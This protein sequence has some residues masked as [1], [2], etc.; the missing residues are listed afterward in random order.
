MIDIKNF[1]LERYSFT[2]KNIDTTPN[3]NLGMVLV[4]PCFNEPNVLSSLLSLLHAQLP[5][6][7]VEVI[8]VVNNA[9]NAPEEIRK[10]NQTTYEAL[11]TWAEANSSDEL[12]FYPLFFNDLPKKHAGVGL[13]RK[14]G[15]DEA[16]RRFIDSKKQDGIIVCFDSDSLCEENY[17]LE[18]EKQFSLQPEKEAFGLHFEHPLEGDYFAEEIY[19]SIT[20]YELHLRYYINALKWSGLPSAYQTIGSSMAVRSS[21]YQKEGGMNKR[22]AGE[23]F[24]FLQKYIDKD[25][26]GEIK[27]TKVIPSPRISNR[28][29]FG[30]GKAV[31]DH[32]IDHKIPSTYHLQTFKDLKLFLEQTDSFFRI[33]NKDLGIMLQEL[34]QSI[35]SFLTEHNFER[36]IPEIN[37]HVNQLN[38][39]RNRFFRW[40]NA[41][42]AMKFVHFS[43]DN[44][45]PNQDIEMAA[46]NFL[47]HT[48]NCA[49]EMYNSKLLLQKFREIDLID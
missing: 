1:Y 45:Y 30:T 41:F 40:F 19:N 26:F 9:E 37:R 49:L 48:K 10:N 14:I 25:T 3:H 6:V 34:P 42:M 17:F 35:A 2:R 4:I 21:A 5:K 7:A 31:S 22:K 46:N 23:D 15:M 12:K 33:E 8:I 27:T 24:Y 13:A 16:V 11:Q 32:L 43:R 28:V 44:F 36:V 29:P 39:F 38:T 47:V 20:L 18:I